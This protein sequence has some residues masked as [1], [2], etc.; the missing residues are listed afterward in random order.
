MSIFKPIAMTAAAL[1]LVGATACSEAKGEDGNIID[2]PDFHSET[3]IFDI[4][5]LRLWAVCRH[6]RCRLTKRR[7]FS[8]SLMRVWRKTG[9]TWTCM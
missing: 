3:G 2:K 1:T 4:D 5:A 6:H 9:V 8:A 7:C